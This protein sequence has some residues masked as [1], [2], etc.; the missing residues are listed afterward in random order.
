MPRTIH[1]HL[2]REIYNVCVKMSHHT[3]E[4]II[5]IIKGRCKVT[6]DRAMYDDIMKNKG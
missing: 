1:P 5:Q 3:F 4:D 6:L 2:R